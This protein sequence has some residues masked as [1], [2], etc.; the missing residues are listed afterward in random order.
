VAILAYPRISNHDE[1]QPLFQI[2]GLRVTWARTVAQCDDADVLILP[3]SKHTSSDLAWL[4]QQGLDSCIVRHAGLGR[5]VLGV[6]GGLQMLGEALID[7]HGIDGNAPGLGLLPIVT[8]FESDK[9][10]Q[11]VQSRF[12]SLQGA[13]RALSG[14]AVT[15]YEIH[16]GQTRLHPAMV[17]AGDSAS[18]VLPHGLAWQNASGNVLGCYVHGLFENTTILQALFGVTHSPLDAAFERL[19][20]CVEQHV[21][22]DTLRSLA[23]GS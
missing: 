17:Q 20:D 21:G 16:H 19:A 15:G 9:I 7:P 4:R 22:I 14:V 6:C 18:E 11:P 2:P 23:T 1:F 8:V 12:T 13:W 3:G 5:P 10:V